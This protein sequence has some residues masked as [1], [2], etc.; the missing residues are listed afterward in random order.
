MVTPVSYLWIIVSVRKPRSSFNSPLFVMEL[1]RDPSPT[2][3]PPKAQG[4]AALAVMRETN[5]G[6]VYDVICYALHGSGQIKVKG[7]WVGRME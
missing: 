5:E 7:E 4:T 2:S 6:V 3:F 1:I